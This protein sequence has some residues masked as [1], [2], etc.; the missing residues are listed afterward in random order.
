MRPIL[1]GALA[2]VALALGAAR[3][4]DLPYAGTW[5]VTLVQVNSATG[6]AMELTPWLV[7]LDKGDRLTGKVAAAYDKF[8]GTTFTPTSAD[9]K[10]LHFRL[11]LGGNEFHVAAYAPKGKKKP[12]RL[13]GSVR[14]GLSYYPAVLE[15]TDLEELDEKSAFRP[16]EGA[17]QLLKAL[18]STD[19]EDREKI[20]KGLTREMAGKP[21]ALM[22]AQMLVQSQVARKV[23]PEKLKPALDAYVKES[24]AYG[25]ELELN[26]NADSALALMANPKAGA[27]LALKYASRAAKLL[28]EGDSTERQAIVLRLQVAILRTTEKKE[29][30]K[31]LE[32]RLAKLEDLLDKEY[33]ARSLSFKPPR[34]TGR[35]G[36][37]DRV[38][39]VELFTGA[40][41]RPCVAPALACDA[42]LKTYKP[43][44]VVLA[45][46]HLH[47]M[48]ANP[49]TN[50]A[51]EARRKYYDPDTDETP[52]LLIDGKEV[53]KA[54]VGGVAVHAKARYDDLR[55][56]ID[57][58]LE[59]PAGARIKL[60]VQRKGDKVD[61]RA[62]VEVK[63]PGKKVKL[64]FLLVEG[65]VRYTGGNGQR[66]HH[67][68]VRALPGGAEG[69]TLLKKSSKHSASV[70]L[71]ELRKK[72]DDYLTRYAADSETHPIP[73][74]QRPLALKGLKVIAL[75]QDDE[76]KS[77]LQAAQANVPEKGS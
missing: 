35:E 32:A 44:D 26:A 65:V 60:D 18:K 34:Y 17:G 36:K 74:D 73:A 3:A 33:L 75:V 39:V 41:C 11:K 57:K 8:K 4:D 52:L 76:G 16:T 70:T 1:G 56:L 66:L 40:H 72:L 2:L 5:K 38:V 55:K 61:M 23:S 62:A 53:P 51:A 71:S 42:L 58:E 31:A 64:R 12:T 14:Q 77:V 29:G 43:A 37:S 27:P 10:S 7:K 22:A 50:P 59:R 20:L 13:L 15:K 63:E 24:S 46:Y 47:V 21:I 6:Q 9:A 45:Q 48:G 68:V 28:R 30:L 49:L 54:K 67:H 25:P 69:F 19:F